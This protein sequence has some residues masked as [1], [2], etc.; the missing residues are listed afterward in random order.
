[1]TRKLT[2]IITIIIA[3]AAFSIS[4][5]AQNNRSAKSMNTRL[6]EIVQLAKQGRAKANPETAAQIRDDFNE[7]PNTQATLSAPITG[8]WTVHIPESDMGG[9]PFDALQTF[10]S[11]GTF[12]ETSSLLGMGGEGPAHGVYERRRRGYVLTFVLFVFDPETGESVGKVRVRASI[13]ML[14]SNDFSAAST[15]DF[16]EP[17]GTTIEDI[18]GGPFSGRRFQVMSN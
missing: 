9:A 12:I 1:M 17:D 11:D 13:R 14:S 4:A 3:A 2:T 10:S 15:V 6:F 8:T 7:D 18:D 5:T 16:I